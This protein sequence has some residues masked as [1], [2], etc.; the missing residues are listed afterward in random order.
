[1]D[2]QVPE[3]E[4]RWLHAV[5]VLGTIVLALILVSQVAVLLAYF[6][7]ILLVLLLGWLLA[8]ILAPVV[9]MP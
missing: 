4:R 8:F 3:S 7:D 5:L 1:M 2:V 9:D 6:T